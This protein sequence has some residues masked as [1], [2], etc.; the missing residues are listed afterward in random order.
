M[1]AFNISG[2]P[3]VTPPLFSY[4]NCGLVPGV[5]KAL[6]K[7]FPLGE[8][9]RPPQPLREITEQLLPL[10]LTKCRGSALVP[11]TPNPT[12]PAHIAASNLKCSFSALGKIKLNALNESNSIQRE[13]LNMIIIIIAL[14]CINIGEASLY[15]KI[16]KKTVN[17]KI[18]NV[19]NIHIHKW[20]ILTSNYLD[21][22][23]F[24]GYG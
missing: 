18:E 19:C 16:Q 22:F 20:Y 8:W 14:L 13:K 2:I 15:K 17:K 11:H 10:L 7:R 1:S 21:I 24:E 6:L 12:V 9:R 4:Y 5:L 23:V 3:F